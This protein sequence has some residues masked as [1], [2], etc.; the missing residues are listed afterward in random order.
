[1]GLAAVRYRYKNKQVYRTVSVDSP[2]LSTAAFTGPIRMAEG[3]GA[4]P[5]FVDPVRRL[6]L[7]D[8]VKKD[9]AQRVPRCPD[10]I[11]CDRGT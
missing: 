6:R 9:D 2:F 1:V 5:V 7:D 3:E 8:S 4:R 10:R 11:G